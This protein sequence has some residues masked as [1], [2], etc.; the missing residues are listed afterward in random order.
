MDKKL[1]NLIEKTLKTTTLLVEVEALYDTKFINVLLGIYRVSFGTLRDIYYLS[2]NEETGASA[3]DLNRKLIE[4]G[5]TVE[6]IIWKGKEKMA[7]KFQ[8]YM[9]VEVHHEI[10]FLKSIGQDLKNQSEELKI[11][12]EETEREYNALNSDTKNRKNWAG[13]SIEKMIEDLHNA[14][15]LEYFESSRIGQAYI[16]GCRLNHVSPFVVHKYLGPEESK[17]AS[18]Y[19][20]RQAIMFGILFHLRLTTR[21]IDEIR[22]LNNSNVYPELASEVTSIYNELE[23]YSS[24]EK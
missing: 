10:E 17:I 14:Q 20:M 15:Q 1:L 4:Y 16:W 7:E 9:H 24:E 13:L 23:N 18:D 12:V 3:L 2:Q 11:G 5:V 21:Y 19:Y 6:Y 8:K 22:I